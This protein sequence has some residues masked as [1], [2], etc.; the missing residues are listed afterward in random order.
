MKLLAGQ[1]SYI[2]A[3]KQPVA[4]AFLCLLKREETLPFQAHEVAQTLSYPLL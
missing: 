2:Q 1:L 3:C 4:I